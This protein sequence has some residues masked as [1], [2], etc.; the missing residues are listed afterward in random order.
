[1]PMPMMPVDQNGAD[2]LSQMKD[3]ARNFL[4]WIK[5]EG[6][7]QEHPAPGSQPPM[8]D[9]PS[10]PPT[11]SNVPGGGAE[12]MPGA[13][14]EQQ[15]I[16][17]DQHPADLPGGNTTP[18]GGAAPMPPSPYEEHP[19]QSPQLLRTKTTTVHDFVDPTAPVA[20][21]PP[22][23]QAQ[24]GA[25]HAAASGNSTLGIPKSVGQEFA[26]ADPGGKLPEKKV[27]DDGPADRFSLSPDGRVVDSVSGKSYSMEEVAQI[28]FSGGQPQDAGIAKVQPA[29]KV[30]V[31]PPDRAQ[32]NTA[33]WT[34]PKISPP[35]EDRFN[36]MGDGE[37]GAVLGR[38]LDYKARNQQPQFQPQQQPQQLND[39]PPRG[40]NMP[41]RQPVGAAPRGGWDSPTF[42]NKR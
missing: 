22:V 34:V 29:G 15:Q 39:M 42:S 8:G 7:E 26:S 4:A 21:D 18:G 13:P 17:P 5:E 31:N 38:L 33:K 12:P 32:V 16:Q 6:Q 3:F 28:L 40:P 30:T 10:R 35:G 9:H 14:F 25:M 19:T 37:A 23:S 27:A 20:T 24:R 41:P 36:R 2:F 1:M 11:G